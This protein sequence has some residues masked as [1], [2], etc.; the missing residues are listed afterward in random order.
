MMAVACTTSSQSSTTKIA[1]A[2][3]PAATSPGAVSTSP[4]ARAVVAA[5]LNCKIGISSGAPGSGGFISFPDGAFTPDP[6]SSIGAGGQLSYLRGQSKWVA[7][8][9][10]AVSPDGLQYATTGSED[11][12][13]TYEETVRTV[14][15]HSGLYTDTALSSDARN[16]RILGYEASG[17]YA[18]AG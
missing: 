11:V 9:R 1:I 7:S 6:S 8:Q 16:V 14:D 12:G 3:S 4:S 17:V 13:S 15:V 5:D 10:S 2:H 18:A